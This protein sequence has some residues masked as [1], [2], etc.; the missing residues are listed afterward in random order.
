MSCASMNMCSSGVPTTMSFIPLLTTQSP[1]ASSSAT[2]LRPSGRAAE[3]LSPT[4]FCCFGC[5]LMS[6]ARRVLS[7]RTVCS[8]VSS[9]TNV[10]A[11]NWHL[12]ENVC[13]LSSSSTTGKSSSSPP[14]ALAATM[15]C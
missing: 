7:A 12:M 6:E 10:V 14:S 2:F 11:W 1:S 5:T 9:I 3:S 4:S 15:A 13:T 8:A